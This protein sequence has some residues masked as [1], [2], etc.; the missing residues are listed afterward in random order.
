M[1][2]N[3]AGHYGKKKAWLYNVF[4]VLKERLREN[5][6]EVTKYHLPPAEATR[7]TS[8]SST[9]PVQ[10][11]APFQIGV[12]EASSTSCASAQFPT[13]DPVETSSYS[14]EAGSKSS[15]KASDDLETM[16]EQMPRIRELVESVD[17]AEHS[18]MER[19]CRVLSAIG[20]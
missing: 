19:C 7:S 5:T 16:E 14:K 13:G 6:L 12:H 4:L 3:H 15:P 1:E 11:R 17:I 18:W 20:I 10:H 2:K 8:A 9:D